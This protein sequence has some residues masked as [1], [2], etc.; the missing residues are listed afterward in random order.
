MTAPEPAIYFPYRQAEGLPKI[1]LVM[2]SPLDAG[3]IANELWK[4]VASLDPN[5]PVARVQAMDDR[6]S[7]SVSKPRFTTALQFAF[8][9]LAV[10]IDWRLRRDELPCSLA[11]K[12][13]RGAAGFGSAARRPRLARPPAGVCHHRARILSRAAR[14]HRAQPIPVQHALRG[15][16]E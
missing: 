15:S 6:L 4:A 10:V 12:R 13:T 5:Q 7:E 14:F 2:R 3:T 11:I 9:G 1:G 16:G 8:A